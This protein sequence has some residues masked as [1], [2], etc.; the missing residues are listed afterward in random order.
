M[1]MRRFFLPALVVAACTRRAPIDPTLDASALLSS[2]R[3]AMGG[4]RLTQV[5]AL[6]AEGLETSDGLI[7]PFSW[8]ADL[9]D[10]RFAVRRKN[11]FFA[12]GKGYDG[13]ARWKL[14]ISRQV[15]VLDSDEGKAIAAAESY[16]ARFGFLF[17]ERVAAKLERLPDAIEGT[18]RWACV[19]VTPFDGRPVTL[20]IDPVRRLVDH[21]IYDRSSTTITVR[22]ADYERV[23]GA[24]LP[25]S[26]RESEG[27]SESALDVRTYRLLAAS[28]AQTYDAPSTAVVDATIAD[29]APS[30][31]APFVLE[32]GK[33]L[34]DARIDGGLPMKFIL[35]TGGRAVLSRDVARQLG[36][37]S[38]CST[39]DSP[40]WSAAPTTRSP[41]SWGSRSSSGSP[42]PWITTPGGSP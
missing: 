16:V 14:D 41:D 21:A 33:L 35:D 6:V 7:G 29:G 36:I 15:H 19:R 1:P 17:P 25:F 37:D 42:S 34:V 31:S 27:A 23:D 4:A 3:E 30:T 13:H 9:D 22:Y 32:G 8:S 5:H 26:V 39:L 24:L 20:S 10:G 40:S 38:W 2:V 12:D 11:D 18:Q 28:P